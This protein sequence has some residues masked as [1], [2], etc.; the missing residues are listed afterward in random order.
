[1]KQNFASEDK[2]STG[3]RWKFALFDACAPRRD[4]TKVV[5]KVH[6]MTEKGMPQ[7]HSI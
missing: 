5:R 1:M 2:M 4:F 3:Y 6:R 7:I